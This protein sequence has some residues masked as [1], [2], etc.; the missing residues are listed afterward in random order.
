M[1]I[2]ALAV[3]VAAVTTI[4]V[5][6]FQLLPITTNRVAIMAT[7]ISNADEKQQPGDEQSKGKNSLALKLV[8]VNYSYLQTYYGYYLISVLS[9]TY[10]FNTFWHVQNRMSHMSKIHPNKKYRL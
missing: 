5:S 4:N 2:V 9:L 7:D 6:G 8:R 10:M 1:I 3:L